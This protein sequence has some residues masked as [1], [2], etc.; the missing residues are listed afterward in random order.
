M[1]FSLF[2]GVFIIEKVG[3]LFDGEYQKSNITNNNVN[4]SEVN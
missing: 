4:D 2:S 3:K 1:E